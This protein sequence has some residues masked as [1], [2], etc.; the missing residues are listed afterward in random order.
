S[1]SYVKDLAVSKQ[2]CTATTG[3]WNGSACK[4]PN[5]I[6]YYAYGSYG[7]GSNGGG[8]PTAF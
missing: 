6:T 7:L 2:A 8:G 3:S 5:N 4:I 1:A